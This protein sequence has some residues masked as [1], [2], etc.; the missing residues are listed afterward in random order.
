M[1]SSNPPKETVQLIPEWKWA[2][3]KAWSIRLAVISAALSAA[4]LALPMLTPVY[5]GKY[6]IVASA[7]VAVAAAVAR[8]VAQKV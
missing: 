2:L 5:P 7:I 1:E 6:L 3:Q 8:V 4:E